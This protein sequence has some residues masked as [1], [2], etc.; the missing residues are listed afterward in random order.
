LLS[1]PQNL[2]AKTGVRNNP[3][4]IRV[5]KLVRRGKKS[6]CLPSNVV[7]GGVNLGNLWLTE[8]SIKCAGGVKNCKKMQKI[9]EKIQRFAKICKKLQKKCTTLHNFCPTPRAFD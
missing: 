2:S 6:L 1:R 8:I 3:V 4:S 5:Q 7:V 9:A